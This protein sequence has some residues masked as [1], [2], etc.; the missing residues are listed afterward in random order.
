MSA[1]IDGLGIDG[2]LIVVGAS[3]EPI[4]VSQ[5]QLIGARRPVAGWPSGT[6]ADLGDTVRFSAPSGVRP[7]IETYPLEEPPKPMSA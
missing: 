3:P 2:K 7:M 1:A 5:R 4:K 6:S